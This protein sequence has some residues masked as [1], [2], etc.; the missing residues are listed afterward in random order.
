MNKIGTLK[1]KIENSLTKQYGKDT[2]K[3]LMK[4]FKEK[5]LNR[6]PIAEAFYIYD[7]LSTQKG[8]D[9]EI[10][11]DYIMESFNELQNIIKKIKKKLRNCLIG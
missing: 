7:Q 5:V 4:T 11:P 3:P 2:F 9:M 6:K 1:S 8:M 10:A